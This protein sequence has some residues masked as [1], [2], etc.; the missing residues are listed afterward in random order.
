MVFPD[1]K[2]TREYTIQYTCRKE[3]HKRQLK[4]KKGGSDSTQT[5]QRNHQRDLNQTKK[6]SFKRGEKI[7]IIVTRFCGNFPSSPFFFFS[8]LLCTC[9]RWV[10]VQPFCLPNYNFYS[11]GCE[12]QMSLKEEPLQGF[13]FQELSSGRLQHPQQLLVNSLYQELSFLSIW[14]LFLG[15]RIVCR[16]G[17]RDVYNSSIW[18]LLCKEWD[19]I[20]GHLFALLFFAT[21]LQC[22]FLGCS[23]SL[24][25]QALFKMQLG[26]R[27]IR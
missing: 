5:K 9:G 24:F 18:C 14:L 10:R 13:L 23:P 1:P 21:A 6:E 20:I 7:V 22:V 27:F 12:G 4:H 11:Q 25:L 2:Y 16:K 26:F 15:P 8:F 3:L 17:S 19:D